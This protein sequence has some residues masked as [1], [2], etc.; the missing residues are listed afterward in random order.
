M[1]LAHRA[2]PEDIRRRFPLRLVQPADGPRLGV[3]EKREVEVLGRS[4]LLLVERV[5]VG[6][7]RATVAARV[8]GREFGAAFALGREVAEE[9][10]RIGR[11]AVAAYGTP[12]HE[13]IWNVG[14]TVEANEA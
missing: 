8:L 11:K 7:V 4:A 6:R 5:A 14:F 12:T 13:G 9:A 3:L 2:T 1:P 10:H